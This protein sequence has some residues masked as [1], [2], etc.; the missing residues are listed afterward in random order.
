V[1]RNNFT[2]GFAFMYRNVTYC[3]TK[4]C[5][6]VKEELPLNHKEADQSIQEDSSSKVVLHSH[7]GDILVLAIALLDF[8]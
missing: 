2:K 1:L 6:T 5:V 3:V 4:S 8:G 7:C